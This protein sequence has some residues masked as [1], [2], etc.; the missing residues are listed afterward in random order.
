MAHAGAPLGKL[1]TGAGVDNID[2]AAASGLL[3]AAAGKVARLTVAHVSDRG[4]FSVVA[5]G[6]TAAGARNAVA[7]AHGDVYVADPQAGRLLVLRAH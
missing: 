1:D 3:Y 6:E 7:D 5:S 2:Y 4:D